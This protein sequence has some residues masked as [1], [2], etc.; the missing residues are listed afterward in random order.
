MLRLANMSGTWDL[1]SHVPQPLNQTPIFEWYMT[2][3]IV[4]NRHQKKTCVIMVEVEL[5]MCSK[6]ANKHLEF[7]GYLH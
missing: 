7:N 4:E 6:Y 5:Y 1:G 3:L 2:R